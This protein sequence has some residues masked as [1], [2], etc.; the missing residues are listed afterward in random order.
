MDVFKA[1][2]ELCDGVE[3]TIAAVRDLATGFASDDAAPAASLDENGGL[4]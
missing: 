3:A 4:P 1:I 2:A